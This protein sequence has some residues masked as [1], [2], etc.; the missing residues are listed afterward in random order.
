MILRHHPQKIGLELDQQGWADNDDMMQKSQ[1]LSPILEQCIQPQNHQH[2]HLSRDIVTAKQ[3]GGRHVKPVILQV[4]S[5]KMHQAGFSFF[6]SENGVWL[7]DTVPAAFL[8]LYKHNNK[9]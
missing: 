5:Q 4:D 9:Y 1:S 2:V 3:V 7:T 8:F 6:I